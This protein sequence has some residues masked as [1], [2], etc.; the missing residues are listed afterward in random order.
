MDVAE[1]RRSVSRLGIRGA[2][3]APAQ[4]L[5]VFADRKSAWSSSTSRSRSAGAAERLWKR[6]EDPDRPFP[7]PP[8]ANFFTWPEL[9]AN[10]EGNAELA[11]R[12]LELVTSH[13]P[14]TA[15]HAY[16]TSRPSMAFHGN[17]QA[18]V[19]EARNLV[20]QGYRVVFFAQSNGRTGAPGRHFPGVLSSLPTG[21]RSR[22]RHVALIWPSAPMSP[23]PP[24]ARS[25]SKDWSGAASVFPEARIAV[26]GSEDLFDSSDLVAKP[27]PTQIATRRL[28]RRSGR[29]EARRLRGAR[30]RTASAD[31]WALARSRKATTRATSC[32]S[33]TPATPSS[34]C[35]SRAWT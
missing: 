17:M 31:F 15:S 2:A 26:F 21:S 28:H 34:T 8:E 30:R 14:L 13:Q 33:N 35:R 32:C 24:P 12:E 4:A 19:A 25:W 9:R 10:L 3:G 27:G 29:S 6:L 1:P 20:E 23:A 18:A 7:C 22:R 16:G 5:A 11:L